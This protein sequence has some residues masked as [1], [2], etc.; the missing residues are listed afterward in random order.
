MPILILVKYILIFAGILTVVAGS[1][2]SI[3]QKRLKR[4]V[5]YSSISQLGFIIVALSI[6]TLEGFVAV[7]FF[8]LIY[9][10]SSI[11]LWSSIVSLTFFNNVTLEKKNSS[12]RK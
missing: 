12:F 9:I 10:I 3:T 6:C 7:Y 2:L 4:F 5:I 11:I 1:Y 8:L